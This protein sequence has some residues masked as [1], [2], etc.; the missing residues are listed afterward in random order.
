MISFESKQETDD[1]RD[2]T[3]QLKFTMLILAYEIGESD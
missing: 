1:L 2:D 3:Y